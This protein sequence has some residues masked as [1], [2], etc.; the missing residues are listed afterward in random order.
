MF[1]AVIQTQS[2]VHPSICSLVGSSL[3]DFK[4]MY[5]D[6]EVSDALQMLDQN[7]NFQTDRSLEGV[8]PSPGVQ[9]GASALK[10]S[11]RLMRWK[12]WKCPKHINETCR[13]KENSVFENM[14]QFNHT[15]SISIPF[16]LF[17]LHHTA[18]AVDV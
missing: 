11:A 7:G 13:T 16:I 10:D 4:T 14:M 18:L 1:L 8:M 6:L 5:L 12:L 2:L 3:Q 17:M 15:Q 9:I